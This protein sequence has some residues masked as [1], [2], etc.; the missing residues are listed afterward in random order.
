MLDVLLSSTGLERS[1]LAELLGINPSMF[2]EWVDGRRSL[3]DSL[4]PM[5][6]SIVGLQPDKVVDRPSDKRRPAVE[7]DILPAIWFKMRADALT[8]ADRECVL[9]IRQLGFLV[10]QLEQATDRPTSGWEVLFETIRREVDFQAPPREQGRSAAHIFLA[11][12]GLS[13]GANGIG[14]VFRGNLRALGLLVV[15]SPISDSKLE[16]CSFYVGGQPKQR[17][18]IFANTHS[19]TWFRRNAILLHE[20]AH[21]I[22][23]AAQSGA[24][25]DFEDGEQFNSVL[26][27]RAEA[28]AQETLLPERVLRHVGQLQGI[29]WDALTPA[30]LAELMAATHTEK[31]AVLAAASDSGLIDAEQVFAY[32]NFDVQPTLHELT[33]HALSTREWA[34]KYPETS[35]W[36]SG[37]RTTTVPGRQLLLPVHYI[38][39]VLEAV[40][41]GYIS[42]SRAAELLMIEEWDF[43]E[44]FGEHIQSHS[45]GE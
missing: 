29:K 28:F 30:S 42:E 32:S 11:H 38:V 33:P 1:R 9:L 23:D 36:W 10:D 12:S 44:R 31:R 40:I 18:C 27:Q 17:P 8:D 43:A 5:L 34:K 20:L 3:P 25:L 26:E 24:S 4:V 2:S 21:A 19:T 14:E 39:R 15:E 22:F 16:G 35:H 6:A 7:G 13:H 41:Q 37:K 45:A